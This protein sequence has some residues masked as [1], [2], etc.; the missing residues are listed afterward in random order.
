[1]PTIIDSLVVELGLDPS[2]FSSEERRAV[3]DLQGLEKQAAQT[4]ANFNRQLSTGLAQLFSGMRQQAQQST[5][6][7]QGQ[8]R[9]IGGLFGLLN[10]QHAQASQGMAAA[11]A[12]AR[13]SGQQISQAGQQGAY[14]LNAMTTAGLAAY[15]SLKSLNGM[16]QS[17]REVAEKTS[18]TM[19]QSMAAGMG[20]AGITRFSAVALA[21]QA[22]TG[23]SPAAAEAEMAELQQALNRSREMG[24]WDER[25]TRMLQTLPP[26]VLKPGDYNLP[27]DELLDKLAVSLQSRPVD[28][29][30]TWARSQGFDALSHYLALPTERRR[31]S[32]QDAMK[33]APTPAEALELDKL[34]EQLTIAEQSVDGLWRA[35][36][37]NLAKSGLTDAIEGLGSLLQY[38]K[39]NKTALDALT[40]G[41]VA[42]TAAMA[43]VSVRT[44]FRFLGMLTGVGAGAGAGA[45]AA[46]AGAGAA[47][48]GGLLARFGLAGLGAWLAGNAVSGGPEKNADWY[49]R[50]AG[51]SG[52]GNRLMRW[53][54]RKGDNV[55]AT[56]PIPGGV[57]PGGAT[58]GG[59]VGRGTGFNYGML[60]KLAMDAGFKGD[61]AAIMA[62]ISMSESS[63]DPWASKVDSVEASYGLTQINARAHRGGEKALGDP[64]Y[65]MSKA[66]E[67]YQS[68]RARGQS[69]FEDWT[70]YTKGLYQQHIEAARAA[71]PQD[72]PTGTPAAATGPPAKGNRG[73]PF[74]VQGATSAFPSLPAPAGY[75]PTS[76][77]G[78][79]GLGRATLEP[80][81]PPSKG[82]ASE[83]PFK[84]LPHTTKTLEQLA[85]ARQSAA[86]MAQARWAPQPGDTSNTSYQTDTRIGS[87]V[88]NTQATD[89]DGIARSIGGALKRN[90]IAEDANMGLDYA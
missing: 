60:K 84:D 88:V 1:M 13:R 51:G 41:V 61:D 35:I 11:A 75:Q 12:S 74:P 34:R 78:W 6:Q 50:A 86:A 46:G 32:T 90:M 37:T 30:I 4:S 20:V 14:G 3:R 33:R 18:Q 77:P 36:V 40:V 57:M 59:K 23:A 56:A 28:A 87:I 9:T 17:T 26:G 53:L 42:F 65:A 85:M 44:I 16:L 68:R 66:F 62:A 72:Y 39:D 58:E 82:S 79:P 67:L 19:R 69:G 25:F 2:K 7:V 81:I 73:Y 21:A 5:S 43:A 27:I 10:R 64:K 48:R 31:T 55:D 22:T 89:A 71:K 80:P 47:A 45:V 54:F 63:G 70:D 83:W 15:A 38:L 24:T 29:R 76:G 8:T 52:L 49:N